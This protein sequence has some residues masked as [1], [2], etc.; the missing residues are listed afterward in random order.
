MGGGMLI[1]AGLPFLCQGPRANST[2]SGTGT[3]TG[4]RLPAPPA[5]T[6]AESRWDVE[7]SDRL[8]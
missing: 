5:L 6:V 1:I 3:D 7:R 4:L 2:S 8:W